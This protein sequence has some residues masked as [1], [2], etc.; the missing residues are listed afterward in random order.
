[1]IRRPCHPF[2]VDDGPSLQ[3]F[4]TVWPWCNS[5]DNSIGREAFLLS[6]SVSDSQSSLCKKLVGPEQKGNPNSGS[7]HV[8]HHSHLLPSAPNWTLLQHNCILFDRTGALQLETWFVGCL[9]EHGGDS[10][11]SS[12]NAWKRSCLGLSWK[13][14]W[15]EK[16]RSFE[17]TKMHVQH[18]QRIVGLVVN[19][20]T[21]RERPPTLV[22]V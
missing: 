17:Q 3:I 21:S 11:L 10:L 9:W 8:L 7:I 5:S 20:T 14:L 13:K 16:W 15:W 18:L 6:S 2:F 1:M 22:S 12:R 4:G 19:K